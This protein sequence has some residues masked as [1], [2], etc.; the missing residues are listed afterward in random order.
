MIATKQSCARDDRFA[1]TSVFELSSAP[2]STLARGTESAGRTMHPKQRA[3]KARSFS[4]TRLDNDFLRSPSSG[5]GLLA[6]M[7]LSLS[8]A[9][10]AGCTGVVQGT[11]SPASQSVS[12][13]QIATT[14]L[15][16]GSTGSSYSASLEV[17]GGVSPYTWST[18]SGQLP[19]GLSLSSSTGAISG[20]PTLAGSFSFNAQVKDSKAATASGGMSINISSSVPP[21]IS[22]VSPNIGSTAGG[23][24]VM[25]FGN[26]F[27]VGTT[28]KFG[29]LPAT[30]VQ[31]ANA[32][33]IQAVAPAET[34]GSVTVTV[35]AVDGQQATLANGFTFSASVSGGPAVPALPQATVD[36]TMPTQGGTVRNVVAGDS[37]GLQTTINSSTCGDTI[38]L[39]AGSTFTGNW[40]IP[41]K[42]CTGWILIQSSGISSLPSGTRVTPSSLASMA[43]LT[44][45]TANPVFSFAASSHN[46][47][48]LGLEISCTTACNSPGQMQAS[49]IETD[50]AATSVSQEPSFI[51]VDRCYV[52]G[53]PTANVKRGMDLQGI[54]LAV[55]DSYFSEIHLVSNDSQA[56]LGWNGSGPFLIQ[57]N[58]LSAAGENIMF[59]GATANITNLVPSDITIVGNHFWKDITWQNAAAPYNWTVK[60]LLEFKYAQRVLVDGNV[61]EYNWVGG[62]T[63]TA[64]LFTPRAELGHVPWAIVADITFTH[65]LLQHTANG[66]VISTNDGLAP[67]GQQG[68]PSQRIKIQNNVLFD[69]SV[70][71]WGSI[72]G[73]TG[74]DFLISTNSNQLEPH[75]FTIDHNTMFNS[76]AAIFVSNT[77]TTSVLNGFQYTNNISQNNVLGN[78]TNPSQ[79]LGS[80]FTNLTWNEN[81]LVGGTTGQYPVVTYFPA[82]L[83]NVGFANLTGGNFQ[84]LSSPYQ[85]AGTDGKD[86]GLWDWTTYS[87]ATAHAL[88]GIFP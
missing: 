16:V 75:D 8:L 39:P 62:Q 46:Y 12:T 33:T 6:A 9:F 35:Q 41:N 55:V 15:P 44:A 23:T 73:G 5:V 64:I 24:T 59:G 14:I 19:N 25:I 30:S 84:L 4:Q 7:I 49:L 22:T 53:T 31:I 82:A 37:A 27:S 29:N 42:S 66:F 13:P 32:T 47:R 1:K 20:I 70:A 83:A 48:L 34:A 10:L 11:N 85:N 51:I 78:G 28:V 26:N 57:N 3:E 81:V 88:S 56:L 72:N 65:N 45:K 80:D 60:N 71:T 63:G 76:N 79:T 36:L 77:T 54:S 74:W 52:H 50:V 68:F 43:T 2:G 38:V 86:I 67:A 87:T 40:T 58:F 61:L 17:T 21:T 18:T 69:V